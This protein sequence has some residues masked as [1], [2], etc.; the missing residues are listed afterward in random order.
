MNS[1]DQYLNHISLKEAQPADQLIRSTIEACRSVAKKDSRYSWL[2]R[3]APIFAAVAVA[4]LACLLLIVNS[5]VPVDHNQTASGYYTI[6]IN[7]SLCISVDEHG[8]VTGVFAQNDEATDMIEQ[9]SIDG[10]S[11]IES[12]KAII[13]AAR[14]NNLLS[15]EELQYVLIGCFGSLDDDLVPQLA[16]MQS[17]FDELFGDSVELL[18]VSGTIEDKTIADQR[19]VSA[20][21]YMLGLMVQ[22]KNVKEGD[23]VSD[24]FDR[25]RQMNQQNYCAPVIALSEKE[26]STVLEWAALD[27]SA[28]G[29]TGK[30][31]YQVLQSDSIMDIQNM[32]ANVIHTYT[33]HSNG[34]QPLSHDLNAKSAAKD[35]ESKYYA[36]AVQ[37]GQNGIK[38]LSNVVHKSASSTV[39]A[40]PMPTETPANTPKPVQLQVSGKI[41]GDKI[42]I[43]W[44]KDTSPLFTE[45]K[46]VAS[47]KNEN[48]I[49]PDDSCIKSVT[50]ADRTSASFHAGDSGLVAAK[51]YYFSVT[52]LYSDGTKAMGGVV[53]LKVPEKESPDPTPDPTPN[54]TPETVQDAYKAAAISGKISGKYAKLSW[55]S[56]S[57]T[58]FCGYKVVYSFSN[59]NPKYPDDG[60]IKY[61]TDKKKRSCSIDVTKLDGYAPGAICY[62]SITV[63]YDNHNIKTAGNAIALTMPEAPQY[64]GTDISA[65]LDGK[66]VNLS[67]NKVNTS[68]FIFYKVVYSF[69]NQSPKYPKNKWIACITNVDTMS[70]SVNDITCLPG[71]EPGKTCS[72]AVTV[73]YLD[74][75]MITNNAA[76]VTYTEP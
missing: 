27:F 63:L 11:V 57:Q 31:I 1:I 60:Y 6:D 56:A 68:G 8:R 23:S 62:F 20:G 71:Y 9:L 50:D 30:V 40:S 17:L 25:M 53:R 43:S 51:H 5:I 45:Y 2:L 7:P 26:D 49:Y 14:D 24:V 55:T 42:I 54:P 37:Y 18:I 75:K 69:N 44:D 41:S 65:S 29:Y 12:I 28:M 3:K 16:D 74:G 36:I 72:F 33:F 13:Y 21:L 64:E 59:P 73:C 70:H 34:S 32:T 10:K 67:W 52:Y 58:G 61:Y 39:E 76:H 35:G 48:P 46:V 66:S 38:K 19:R 22:D 15:S 4:A 47:R